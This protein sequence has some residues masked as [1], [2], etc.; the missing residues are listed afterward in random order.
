MGRLWAG[1]DSAGR[2]A[3]Q[4]EARIVSGK[5]QAEVNCGSKPPIPASSA[6]ARL[7]EGPKPHFLPPAFKGILAS[8]YL[9]RIR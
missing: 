1:Q 7:G 5:C 4:P 8:D 9:G 3:L 6:R 2:T